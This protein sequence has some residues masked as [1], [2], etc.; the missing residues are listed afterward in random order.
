MNRLAARFGKFN[1]VGLLGAIV[2]LAAMSLL[3]K[4]FHMPVAIATPFAVEIAVIHN[5]MWHDRFTW[6]ERRSGRGALDRACR[7]HASNG[8]VSIAGNTILMYW[9]VERMRAPALPSAVLAVVACSALNFLLA[10]R[11]VWRQS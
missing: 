5:L 6:R 3:S 7:F 2:Q 4:F 9:L 11:W 1:F 10:D 8:L